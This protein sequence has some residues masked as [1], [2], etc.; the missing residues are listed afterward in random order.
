MHICKQNMTNKF[1]IAVTADNG[2]YSKCVFITVDSRENLD[3]FINYLNTLNALSRQIK[4][5]TKDEFDKIYN[6]TYLKL[7]EKGRIDLNEIVY[8]CNNCSVYSIIITEYGEN[9]VCSVYNI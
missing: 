3:I 5:P 6:E 4:E 8:H 1:S 2:I 7:D 9:S